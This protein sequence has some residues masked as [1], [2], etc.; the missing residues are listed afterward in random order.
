M[1]FPGGARGKEPSCRCRTHKRHGF[2]PCVRKIP[3]RRAWQPSPVV[4][5]GEFHGQRSLAGYS[6]WGPKELDTIEAT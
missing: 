3:C 5:S 6:P 1:E 2:H 4:S